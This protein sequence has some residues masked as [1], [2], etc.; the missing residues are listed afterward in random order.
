MQDDYS[1]VSFLEKDQGKPKEVP[2]ASGPESNQS[3]AK[4]LAQK[5]MQIQAA[6]IAKCLPDIVKKINV[7]LSFNISELDKMPQNLSTVADAM[8]AFMNV[9]SSMKETLKKIL[10]RGEYDEYPDDFEMHGAARIVDMLNQYS[11]ELP[12]NPLVINE[13]EFLMEEIQVL[14]E[15]KT[16]GLPNFLPESAF[17]TL[18]RRKIDRISHFTLEFVN[19]VW[20]YIEEVVIKV[21]IR[22]S[23]NYPQLQARMTSAA[24][25]LIEKQKKQSLLSVQGMID[26]ETLCAY[27]SNPDYMK[28]WT[29]LMKKQDLFMDLLDDHWKSSVC[30]L[31]WL[32]KV[33]ISHL[34][35]QNKEMAEMA[36]DLR[37]RIIAYWR[38][39][40]LR[41]VDGPALHILFYVQK[42]VEEEMDN[43]IVNEIVGHNGSGLEKMLEESPSVAGKRVRL[44]KSIELLKDAKQ[45]V[46]RILDRIQLL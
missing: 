35:Q 27:T 22:H 40:V 29:A 23:D 10:V 12:A 7:K 38:T 15:A 14:E 3:N 18:L 26:M 33:N 25:N 31:D 34:R 41:L 28:T 2:A 46:T 45:V 44:Q 8:R 17:K 24:R 43:E 11:K 13:G 16:V 42:L 9:L 21:L 5:L 1:L 19:Q 37:M 4:V 36:F 20:N 30:D 32:G 39:V 6:S